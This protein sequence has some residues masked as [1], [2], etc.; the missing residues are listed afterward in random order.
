[1]AN[2]I[3]FTG[4]LGSGKSPFVNYQKTVNLFPEIAKDGR[5]DVALYPTPGFTT[6]SNIGIAPVR[7]MIP[8]GNLLYVVC[9]NQ[10]MQVSI[11]GSY[12][13]LGNISSSDGPV[14]FASNGTQIIFVDGL[15]GYLYV[16]STL[17]FTPSIS[18]V[19]P[20]F[21]DGATHVEFFDGY[22]LA[23]DPKNAGRFWWSDSYNGLSWNGLSFATA[24]RSPDALQALAVNGR[25]LWLLGTESAEPW[26]NSGAPI[27]PFQ[28]ISNGFSEWGCAAPYSVATNNGVIY[29]LTANKHGHGQVV[30]ASGMQPQVISS[31]AIADII[32]T[33]TT[34]SDA[35]GYTYDYQRH[36][37]YVLTFPTANRT[38]VYD[39][40][41]QMWHEWSTN[42]IDKRHISDCH[43]MFQ[44]NHILGSSES[45]QLLLMDWNTYKDGQ[46]PIHRLRRSQYVW[47]GNDGWVFHNKVRVECEAGVGD[48]TTITPAIMLRWSNDGG[49]TW[50]AEQWRNLG[51]TGEY[52]RVA[53]WRKLSRAKVRVYEV[54]V[55]D[56]VKVIIVNA[57][58]DVSTTSRGD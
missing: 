29:W 25:E 6:F 30:M 7:G 51:E 14:K 21:P 3:P 37:F 13:V 41:T 48:T 18:V 24:E 17:T 54:K 4:E 16:P 11:T 42:G 36:S 28:P 52:L 53:E 19:A 12:T 33:F 46:Y 5:A 15:K 23:N 34:I 20:N 9:G 2:K 10:F 55:T 40:T 50:S 45:G 47:D 35:F 1:M 22:F 58:V 43:V 38:F 49:K 27:D 56:P 57:Y 32:S 44:N 39:I 31:N 8:F 26:Y